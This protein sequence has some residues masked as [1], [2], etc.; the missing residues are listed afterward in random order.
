MSA[1]SYVIVKPNKYV[2][3]YDKKND[4]YKTI[5]LTS[6]EVIVSNDYYT[7]DLASDIIDYQGT[8]VVLTSGI[9]NLNTIDMKD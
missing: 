1:F 4:I 3:Y 8:N 7:V 5:D 6:E 9:E 2:A